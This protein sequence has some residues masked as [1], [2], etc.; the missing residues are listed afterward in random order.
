MVGMQRGVHAL[1]SQKPSILH[2]DLK[3]GNLLV[4]ASGLV[5][6]SDFGTSHM[7]ISKETNKEPRESETSGKDSKKEKKDKKD[8]K[9]KN[10]DKDKAKDN[11]TSLHS[12]KSEIQL[13]LAGT[14]CYMAPEVISGRNSLRSDIYSVGVI[15]WQLVVR[16]MTGAYR[17]CLFFVICMS[18]C[19]CVEACV[20]VS[21][22]KKR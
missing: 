19:V 15:L 12:S 1:H 18:V 13:D 17:V 4:K 9:S 5:K 3:P 16:V 22:M 20:S 21:M 7:I 11:P 8:K 10:K 2:R 6:V 14:V